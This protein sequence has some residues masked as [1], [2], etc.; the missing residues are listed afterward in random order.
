MFLI[1]PC[2]CLC[3]IYWSHVLS[4]EWR[5]SWSSADRRGDAPTT[6][7]WSKILLPTKMRLISEVWGHFTG[8]EAIIW[9]SQRHW[10]NCGEHRQIIPINRV[11]LENINI[12][13]S[14]ITKPF[15]WFMG[16]DEVTVM[17]H[18]G[19]AQ[20]SAKLHWP[21]VHHWQFCMLHST[22]NKVCTWFYCAWFCRGYT[23]SS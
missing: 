19:N 7:E 22:S 18:Y 11:I 9:L 5:C 16:Y 14:S 1:S 15:A 6:S 20:K 8:T 17:W 3:T 21:L 4:G 23:T 10:S 13:K 2:S 12:T